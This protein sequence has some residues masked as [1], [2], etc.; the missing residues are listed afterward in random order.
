MKD[1]PILSI[2]E[3]GDSSGLEKRLKALAKSCVYVGIPSN[4]EKDPRQG[5][6]IKN[7]ELAYIHEFGSGDGRIPPRPFM[8]PAIEEGQ[9]E[10]KAYLA[11]ACKA[12]VDGKESDVHDALSG[13]GMTAVSLIKN[14][15]NSGL[16]PPLSPS[17]LKN[18][19]RSR[20]TKGKRKTEELEQSPAKPLINTGQLLNSFTYVVEMK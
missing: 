10:I 15:I 8:G 7:H 1:Q 19:H 18:R 20:M 12:A 5:S 16:T 9:T 14:K 11:G 4:D 3:F 2:K 6:T 13:A 17:T